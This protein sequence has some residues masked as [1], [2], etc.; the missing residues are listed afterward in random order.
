LIS[1]FVFD[2][3]FPQNQRKVNTTVMT[4]YYYNQT[5]E[6][7]TLKQAEE[8]VKKLYPKQRPL[9]Q[10]HVDKLASEIIE[11]K[12]QS[13]LNN[14]S[15]VFIDDEL[16]N[17]H[18]RLQA[19]IKAASMEPEM[20]VSQDHSIMR[21]NDH[22]MWNVIDIQSIP[23][24]FSDICGPDVPNSRMIGMIINL[25]L[26]YDARKISIRSPGFTQEINSHRFKYLK[27]NYVMLQE[28]IEKVKEMYKEMITTAKCSLLTEQVG[29]TFLILASEKIEDRKDAAEFIKFMYSGQ[30]SSIIF[31]SY[32][33]QLRQ[34]LIGNQNDKHEQPFPVRIKLAMLIKVYN[35]FKRGLAEM[36]EK[37]PTRKSR[38]GKRTGK[39]AT[40]EEGY[41]RFKKGEKFPRF[42]FEDPA[43]EFVEVVNVD[44]KQTEGAT[45]SSPVE[46]KD[47]VAR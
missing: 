22:N 30:S 24:S 11:R 37:S 36:K 42:Y 34:I 43:A 45:E 47:L 40:S 12:G 5:K 10:A 26:K 9:R 39:K 31:P 44:N 23:R 29:S 38:N 18:H 1:I 13:Q 20:V 25:I 27:E 46:V 14:D 4:E 17:G 19:L 3:M 32:V 15:I 7:I 6:T 28:S 21:T 41:I 16:A 35:A 2:M 8:Y 33:G